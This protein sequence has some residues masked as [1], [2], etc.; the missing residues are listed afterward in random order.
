MTRSVDNFLTAEEKQQISN[1][2]DLKRKKP[3]TF[4]KED[5]PNIEYNNLKKSLID[6]KKRKK[7]EW[8]N[9]LKVLIPY[10]STSWYKKVIDKEIQCPIHQFFTTLTNLVEDEGLYD[11][12]RCI[13][14]ILEN[15]VKICGYECPCPASPNPILPSRTLPNRG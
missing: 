4:I 13:L 1:Y 11:E 3:Y 9:N 15:G 7:F 2:I 12:Q 10:G 6:L 14:Q 8:E 5:Y